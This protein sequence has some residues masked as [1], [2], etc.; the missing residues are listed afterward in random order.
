M[1][2]VVPGE[3]KFPGL[4]LG[5]WEEQTWKKTSQPG[6]PLHRNPACPALPCLCAYTAAE[7]RSRCGA[8]PRRDGGE[9]GGEEEPRSLETVT[10]WNHSRRESETHPSVFPPASPPACLPA[11]PCFC[12]IIQKQ[13]VNTT[14]TATVHG[15]RALLQSARGVM[16]VWN[17]FIPLW[18]R[19]SVIT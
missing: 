17:I 12:F 2:W 3:T 6:L 7:Q 9:R 13:G 18:L 10:D 19:C 14:C 1:R 5:E 4:L 11:L 15:W 16:F 8:G